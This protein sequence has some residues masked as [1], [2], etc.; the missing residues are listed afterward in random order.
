MLRVNLNLWNSPIS[1]MSS[2]D[3]IKRVIAGVSLET[4]VMPYLDELAA[5]M[6]MSRS[7]VLN[8][9]VYEYAKILDSKNLVPLAARVEVQ[10]SKP[11]IIKA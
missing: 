8:T 9:I 6:G 3:N 2:R 1:F 11:V 7:W 10:G 4:A 5:R